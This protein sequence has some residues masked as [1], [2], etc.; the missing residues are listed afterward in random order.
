VRCQIVVLGEKG[1]DGAVLIAFP[2]GYGQSVCEALLD[3]GIEWGLRP[4][5]ETAFRDWL[6]KG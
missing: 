2:R 5:G 3:A 4:A 1:D 6:K